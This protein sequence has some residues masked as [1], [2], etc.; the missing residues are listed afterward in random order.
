MATYRAAIIGC[1]ARAADHANAYQR[2][3]EARLVACCGPTPKRR[4]EF[5][6]K[7]G[8]T[9]YADAEEMIRKEKPDIVHLT[10][11]P[12]A[13]VELL[14]LVDAMGVPLC[15]TEKPLATGVKD[16]RALVTLSRTCRTKIAISHQCRWQANL[17]RCQEA[18]RSG[19]L[20]KVLMLDISAGMNIAGQ[21][22]HVLNYGMSLNSESR[23]TSVFGSANGWSNADRMHPGADTTQATLTFANGVRG[24]WTSGDISPRCG[25]PTTTWQ[26]VRVAA[27]AER[28]RVVW[29]EFGKWEIVADG[30]VECGSFGGFDEW[31]RTNGMAQVAFHRAMFTWLE[32]PVSVPG[33]SFEQSLHEWSVVL[34]LYQSALTR[35][36]VCMDA[37]NP[38]DDLV[39]KLT[40]QIQK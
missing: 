14:T 25:D 3:P 29:E 27:Y 8:I 21:G 37:F 22:T 1:G 33:T 9:A 16:W 13:R 23:V 10:T 36:N 39:E 7:F 18:L 38:A 2:L 20:G 19:R 15:T 11:P 26:H 31:R 30:Q 40:E 12:W 34:A 32:N 35:Q 28:G 6:A 17:A 5:A 24:T 4:E